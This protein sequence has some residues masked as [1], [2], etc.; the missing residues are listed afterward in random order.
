VLPGRYWVDAQGNCGIEGGPA[1]VNLRVAAAQAAGGG[2]GGGA[3]GPWSY[4]SSFGG[5]AAGD[6]QGNYFY[7]DGNTS[8]SNW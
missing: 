8:W 5:T 3:G 4:T 1:F 7:S 6:G 2:A